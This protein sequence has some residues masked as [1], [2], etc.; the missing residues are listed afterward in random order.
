MKTKYGLFIQRST[1]YFFRVD[2]FIV[3]ITKHIVISIAT[4][5][6]HSTTLGLIPRGITSIL[7]ITLLY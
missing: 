4:L 3:Q 2:L 1:F 6:F 5:H 7:I